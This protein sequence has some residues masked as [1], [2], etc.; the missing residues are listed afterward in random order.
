MRFSF[1]I[2]A[3]LLGLA[4]LVTASNVVELDSNNFDEVG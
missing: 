4:A 3:A 2:P 1:K